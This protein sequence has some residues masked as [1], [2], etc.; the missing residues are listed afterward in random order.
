MANVIKAGYEIVK[1]ESATKHIEKVGR[2]CYKSE[3]AICEGS[4][5]RFI[6]KLIDRE[7][8]AML[9]HASFVFKVSSDLYWKLERPYHHLGANF[10]HLTRNN[11]DGQIRYLVSGNV[12]AINETR[13]KELLELLA[14]VNPIL[15]YAK[16]PFYYTGEEDIT[17][18]HA[19]LVDDVMALPELSI[20]EERQHVYYTILFT[21]DRGVTHELVRMRP[22][23]FAQESTR[24][25]NYFKEKF[26]SEITV[27][28]IEP[29]L[30][31][32]KTVQAGLADGTIT[33]DDI[34]RFIVEWKL[35][36]AESEIHYM[37]LL[38]IINIPEMARSVLPQSVK[39]DINMTS[40]L[41]QWD[42]VG[43]LRVADAAHPQMREIMIPA[44]K[45]L[46]G[47]HARCFIK[48]EPF[49]KK[50]L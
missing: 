25:C 46:Y 47:K 32:N 27:I 14:E 40:N 42:W 16:D 24:Y 18:R 15:A 19:E 23:S 38:N 41:A 13:C 49:I 3:G 37:N 43:H 45:E 1:A 35:A 2:V 48:T 33:E 17:R 5:E 36:M 4:D 29:G 39:A 11:I 28:D 31:L 7:H 21:V 10:L 12:R 26:G 22:D 20:E 6:Q 8:T 9:E 44:I 34:Q 30:R 50:Y